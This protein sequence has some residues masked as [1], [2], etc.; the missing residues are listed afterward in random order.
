[1]GRKVVAATCPMCDYTMRADDRPTYNGDRILVNKF[2]YDVRDPR[3][4]EV[5]VFKY[6]GDAKMN[7]IKRLIGLPNETVRIYQ[8]DIFIKRG[9]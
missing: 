9:R 5:I 4:W 6:P 8:G 3:R 2:V 1:M 7:Y